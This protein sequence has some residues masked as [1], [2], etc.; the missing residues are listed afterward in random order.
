MRFLYRIQVQTV[1]YIYAIKYSYTHY[2]PFRTNVEFFGKWDTVTE[3]SPEM[4]SVNR[5]EICSIANIEK[6]KYH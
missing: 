1:E 4:R 5:Y 6:N 2:Y 3:P